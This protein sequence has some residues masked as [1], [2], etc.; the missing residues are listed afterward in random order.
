MRTH[1]VRLLVLVALALPHA[2][3]AQGQA[4][5]KPAPVKV[6]KPAKAPAQAAKPSAKPAK[7]NASG[8]RIKQIDITKGDDVEGG[9]AAGTGSD[10][11]VIGKVVHSSLLRLRMDF[12]DHLIRSAERL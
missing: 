10:V 3:L 4:P 5:A 9:I 12:N 8:Q 1:F 6:A 7:P 11:T 2:A